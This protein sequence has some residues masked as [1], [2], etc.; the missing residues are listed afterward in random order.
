MLRDPKELEKGAS[1]FNNL[2]L[3]DKHIP[4]DRFRLDDPEIKKHVVGSTG[5]DA[6]FQDGYLDNSLVIHTASAIQDVEAEKKAE[7]SCAYR[8][9]PD[10]TPG[11]FEGK[12]YDGIMRDIQGNHV[13]LVPEGRAGHDVKVMDSK[14]AEC[15]VINYSRISD[16]LGNDSVARVRHALGMDARDS[17][18]GSVTVERA[19]DSNPE[20]INQ[21]TALSGIASKSSEKAK[22]SGKRDDHV[23]AAGAHL[24]AAKV[25]PNELNRSRHTA[26]AQHHMT[27]LP[28]AHDSNPEGLNQYSGAS[29]SAKKADKASK[30]ADLTTKYAMFV[31]TNK[32]HQIA[33]AAHTA[34][35][36]EHSLAAFKASA[37]GHHDEADKHRAAIEHHEQKYK[38]HK[39]RF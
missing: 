20:G 12:H 24:D 27:S 29:G 6:T 14:M 32:A 18:S 10:M 37:N 38:Y 15:S 1:T 26:M 8:Y 11:T 13:S 25:A 28:K 31:G 19:K 16:A 34:A 5:T 35:K 33:A 17:S 39:E 9:T 21:Y 2:P 4:L 23:K 30:N 7:L 3:L 36:H 22:G